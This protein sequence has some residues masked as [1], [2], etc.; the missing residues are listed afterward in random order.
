MKLRKKRPAHVVH[1]P[2]MKMARGWCEGSAAYE[3]SG[4]PVRVYRCHCT[5]CQ[6]AAVSAFSIDVVVPPGAPRLSGKELRAA[7]GERPP[8]DGRRY[9]GDAL[10]ARGA[11]TGAAH[12]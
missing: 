5:D 8:R 7:P 12:R 3:F 4:Q 6:R 9:A 2:G 1:R 11:S 10:R